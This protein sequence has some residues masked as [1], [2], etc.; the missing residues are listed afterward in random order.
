MALRL[1]LPPPAGRAAARIARAVK[2]GKNG[3]MRM[4]LIVFCGHL[5][6]AAVLPAARGGGLALRLEAPMRLDA[7]A[8]EIAIER[9]WQPLARAIRRVS[10]YLRCNSRDTWYLVICSKCNVTLYGN[11]RQADHYERV[12]RA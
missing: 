2:H 12:P 5:A 4:P 3:A 7:A 11:Q 8:D 6:R 1:N 9:R 10:D